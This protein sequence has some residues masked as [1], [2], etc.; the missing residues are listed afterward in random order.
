MMPTIISIAYGI[1]LVGFLIGLYHAVMRG[2]DVQALGITAI[3]YL[4]VAI[5]VANWSTIFHD[6]NNSFNAVAQMIGNS[7]LTAV[8]PGGT[9]SAGT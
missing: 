1:L 9:S 8:F 7:S 3:K 6:L 4:V 2:G 5:V